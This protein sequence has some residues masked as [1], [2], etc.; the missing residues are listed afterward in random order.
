MDARLA[1][2]FLESCL[3]NKFGQG[4]LTDAPYAKAR[5]N[6]G[7]V[8]HRPNPR[9]LK[10]EQLT[11]AQSR[12]E[13]RTVRLAPF[14]F[15]TRLVSACLAR[16]AP[17]GPRELWLCGCEI[18]QT[19][20]QATNDVLCL[21]K[22]KSLRLCY[23]AVDD[24]LS[25]GCSRSAVEQFGVCPKLKDMAQFCTFRELRILWARI[26]AHPNQEVRKSKPPSADQSRLIN[27]P[28]TRTYCIQS[29]MDTLLQAHAGC[30]Y[31]DS[32]LLGCAFQ[33]LKD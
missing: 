22:I 15:A 11:R 2:C 16:W 30:R 14:A 1:C 17:E 20:H 5:G 33:S 8:R 23:G 12:Y 18:L 10:L 9:S 28:S 7:K 27:N 19:V 31:P 13:D 26:A 29:A 4:L 25:D 24:T 32:S 3:G 21:G 6:V